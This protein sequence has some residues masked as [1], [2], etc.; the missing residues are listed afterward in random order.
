[1]YPMSLTIVDVI[2]FQEFSLYLDS[3]QMLL[4]FTLKEEDNGI[5]VTINSAGFDQSLAN[6]KAL[7]EGKA[8]PYV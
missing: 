2:P 5:R 8:I 6:L 1:M 3:Q 4:S 7:I